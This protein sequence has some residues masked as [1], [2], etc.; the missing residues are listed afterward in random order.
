MEQLYQR[1]APPVHGRAPV[2]DPRPGPAA[3]QEAP[4]AQGR[5]PVAGR[6]AVAAAAST[7]G[8]G[9]AR[10]WATR[11]AA[12]PRSPVLRDLEPG[13]GTPA[14]SPRRSTEARSSKSPPTQSVLE[15]AVASAHVIDR[16][17]RRPNRAAWADRVEP[18]RPGPGRRWRGVGRPR[19]GGSRG[20]VRPRRLVAA[21]DAHAVRPRPSAWPGN[22]GHRGRRGAG[23]AAPS[24]GRPGPITTSRRRCQGRRGDV[25]QPPTGGQAHRRTAPQHRGARGSSAACARSW[26]AGGRAHTASGPRSCMAGSP[27]GIRDSTTAGPIDARRLYRRPARSSATASS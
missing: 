22:A 17:P 24:S 11:N 18:L 9:C 8:A 26:T 14:T 21:A 27:G 3:A 20:D 7:P 4:R 10:S 6:A 1:P 15:T 13:H 19:C 25:G 2:G 12:S 23:A 16:T 5:R